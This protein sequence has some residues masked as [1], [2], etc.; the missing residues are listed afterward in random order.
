MDT[1]HLGFINQAADV[2]CSQSEASVGSW[3]P[4][5][6]TGEE[7]WRHSALIRDIAITW[8]HSHH[9][10]TPAARDRRVWKLCHINA[11]YNISDCPSI[12]FGLCLT[13]DR[14]QWGYN[15][16][17]NH[18]S[19]FALA[20]SPANNLCSL[21]RCWMWSQCCPKHSLSSHQPSLGEWDNLHSNWPT[22]YL[23]FFL[24]IKLFLEKCQKK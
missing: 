19:Y 5:R 6:G 2:S 22:F 10:G 14:R 16:L 12:R 11:I 21:T 23:P 4:I 17:V 24:K 1:S 20:S 18:Y 8:L 13:P 15:L 3:W 7:S 9:W